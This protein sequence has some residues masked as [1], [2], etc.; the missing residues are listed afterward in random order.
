MNI[1]EL[2]EGVEPKLPGAPKGIKIMTPQQFV[3]DAGDENVDEATKLAAPTRPIGD[4]E[5]TDY[6]D[7]IRNRE[8]KK[9]DKYKL[10]YIHRSSVVSYYNEEGKSTILTL[11][12][13]H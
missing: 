4:P 2:M 1:V 6:L 13:K 8:K 3:A 7:R 9:T 11:S 5:L 12:N 10:P